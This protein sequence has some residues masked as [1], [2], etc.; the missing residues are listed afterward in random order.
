MNKPQITMQST[1]I[2]ACIGI[3]ECLARKNDEEF[4][5]LTD[6]FNML[7]PLE[8]HTEAMFN[9]LRRIT[10]GDVT[11][12]LFG[13]VEG[14]T[15]SRAYNYYRCPF[16]NHPGI[17]KPEQAMLAMLFI[18]FFHCR[19]VRPVISSMIHKETGKDEI[20]LVYTVLGAELGCGRLLCS[21]VTVDTSMLNTAE[22]EELDIGIME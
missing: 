13:F 6:M 14:N 20:G 17:R 1:D 3:L 12:I 10:S 19:Y 4:T 2:R 15:K 18:D 9:V 8:V 5:A 16:S 22:D 7:F 11:N 21:G